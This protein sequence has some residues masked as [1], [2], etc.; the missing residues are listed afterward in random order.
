MSLRSVILKP[1]SFNDDPTMV[2]GDQLL[3]RGKTVERRRTCKGSIK[4]YVSHC[5]SLWKLTNLP[6]FSCSGRY[7]IHTKTILSVESST[8]VADAFLTRVPT[9]RPC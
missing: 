8:S 6:A 1:A 3:I 7:L 5:E 2:S 9:R 4:E